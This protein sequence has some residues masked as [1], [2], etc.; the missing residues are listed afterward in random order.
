[1]YSVLNWTLLFP[2]EAMCN[3][4]EKLHCNLIG[5]IYSSVRV[6]LILASADV[7]FIFHYCV[8]Q[9][10]RKHNKRNIN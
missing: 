2:G 4:H 9:M 3:T 10:K 6:V 5:N 8:Q 7:Y 1:M